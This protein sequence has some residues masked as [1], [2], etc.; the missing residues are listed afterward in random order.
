MKFLAKTRKKY[1]L[2]C[3]EMAKRLGIS[4]TFYWQIE[5][6]ERRLYY[7]MAIRIADIFGMKPDDLFY[8]DVSKEI[9]KQ[10]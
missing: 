9:K 8:K 10:N 7:E 6:G 3:T 4:K 2:N 5:H 1:N